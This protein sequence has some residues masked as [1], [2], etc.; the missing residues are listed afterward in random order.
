MAEHIALDM[1][2]LAGAAVEKSLRQSNMRAWT[3]RCAAFDARLLRHMHGV[4]FEKCA[5]VIADMRG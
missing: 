1:R 4:R 3:R 5:L 2:R